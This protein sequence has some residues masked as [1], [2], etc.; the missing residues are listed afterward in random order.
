MRDWQIE[1]LGDV[2]VMPATCP[3]S[4]SDFVLAFRPVSN[5]RVNFELT[6]R[7]HLRFLLIATTVTSYKTA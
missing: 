6:V 2:V 7:L 1:S 5:D 4:I 3:A